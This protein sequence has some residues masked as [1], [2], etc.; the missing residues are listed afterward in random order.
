ML[1]N[2]YTIKTCPNC[3]KFFA[4]KRRD[5]KYCGEKS[6]QNS[7]VTCAQYMSSMSVVERRRNDPAAKLYHQIYNSLRNKTERAKPNDIE[8]RK[9]RFNAFL[10]KAGEF[11]GKV[12]SGEATEQEYIKWLEDVKSGKESLKN[13]EKTT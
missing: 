10:N 3:K 1:E 2:D 5:S 12:E 9:K 6:P 8:D 13:G 7:S 11:K 4:P